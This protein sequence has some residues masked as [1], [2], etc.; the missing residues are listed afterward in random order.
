MPFNYTDIVNLY[1]SSGAVIDANKGTYTHL[2]RAIILEL[3]AD[4]DYVGELNGMASYNS[5][6][7]ASGHYIWDKGTTIALDTDGRHWLSYITNLRSACEDVYTKMSLG[8]PT[9]TKTISDTTS[10]LYTSAGVVISGNKG[11][12]LDVR[13]ASLYEDV[14]T[15]L[16]NIADNTFIYLDAT[17]GSDTTGDGTQGNP[18]QTW[19]KGVTVINTAGAGNLYLFAGTYQC[20]TRLTPNNVTVTGDVLGDVKLYTDTTPWIP[21]YNISNLTI[22]N[23]VFLTDLNSSPNKKADWFSGCNYLTLNNC[24]QTTLSTVSGATP[25][26]SVSS[27]NNLVINHCSFILKAY[28]STPQGIGLTINS[29]T[30]TIN[31]SLFVGFLYAVYGGT[32]TLTENNCGFYDNTNQHGGGTPPTI[33]QTNC[34]TSDPLIND[35]LDGH[36]SDTSPYIDAAADGFDIGMFEDGWYNVSRTV[37]D[38]LVMTE[39]VDTLLDMT[40]SDIVYMKE[41]LTEVDM[42]VNVDM[43]L[44]GLFE[45]STAGVVTYIDTTDSYIVGHKASGNSPDFAYNGASLD[46][47]FDNAG[48]DACKVYIVKDNGSSPYDKLWWWDTF[49]TYEAGSSTFPY[50]ID[51]WKDAI[52]GD[53]WGKQYAFSTITSDGVNDKQADITLKIRVHN[54]IKDQWSE[55]VTVS[56]TYYFNDWNKTLYYCADNPRVVDN[57]YANHAN[58]YA[59]V[60]HTGTTKYTRADGVNWSADGRRFAYNPMFKMGRHLRYNAQNPDYG[61][62]YV[63]WQDRKDGS[64]QPA[65]RNSTKTIMMIHACVAVNFGNWNNASD[66]VFTLS[67]NQPYDGGTANFTSPVLGDTS[68]DIHYLHMTAR[69]GSDCS[70]HGS[71]SSIVV[72]FPSGENVGWGDYISQHKVLQDAD[73]YYLQGDNPHPSC[74]G[75]KFYFWTLDDGGET[76]GG[77][78][79]WVITRQEYY[80][81]TDDDGN[82]YYGALNALKSHNGTESFSDNW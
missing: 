17:G 72:R 19:N 33:T 53:E 43:F 50:L 56:K 6:W 62:P 70:G 20:N 69:E 77:Y 31:D 57:E 16:L 21:F 9:W 80:V 25:V 38:D 2:T 32:G 27:C 44:G 36:L 14:R 39:S 22:N 26:F 46:I 82:Y 1:N 78:S 45:S 54:T 13:W 47:S 65:G 24:F 64:L 15:A 28:L 48:G 61:I 51:A 18:Y 60:Y 41:Q 34:L 63:N 29:A 68:A 40:V 30:V 79:A 7:D 55:L 35:R 52:T 12:Y 58:Y 67:T 66:E 3:R 59:Q 23:I 4:I 75:N 76:P 11:T 8:T 5:D 37:T 81:N 74:S 71:H 73:I 10:P 49:A 42:N